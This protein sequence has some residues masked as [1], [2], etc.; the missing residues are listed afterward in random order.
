M[1]FSVTL[2]HIFMVIGSVIL[3]SAFSAYSFYVSS[4]VQN[5]MMQN[6]RDMASQTSLQLEIVYA[7]LDNSTTPASFVIYAKNI[8]WTPLDNYTY[9]DVYAGEYRRAILY[10]YSQSAQNGS[11]AFNVTDANKNGVWEPMETAVIKAYPQDNLTGVMYEV[12][13]FP[14][15]GI[16]SSYLFPAPP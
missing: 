7:T 10:T 9:L 15:H 3:A 14:F 16:G 6:A 4:I 11:G 8:G 13:V 2:S 1:G 12:R 5:S